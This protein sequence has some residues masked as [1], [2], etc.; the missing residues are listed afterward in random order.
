M[1]KKPHCYLFPGK[2]NGGETII[3]ALTPYWNTINQIP[4]QW[5]QHK[6]LNGINLNYPVN[7]KLWVDDYPGVCNLL[8][9]IIVTSGAV[10]VAD[11]FA[12][13]FI[14]YPDWIKR[15]GH[16][17]V[18]DTQLSLFLHHP[19]SPC[20]SWTQNHHHLP[21]ASVHIWLNVWIHVCECVCV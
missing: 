4:Q 16:L 5:P 20:Y 15:Q 11:V 1:N 6:D 17:E 21:D 8:W 3:N 9:K 19:T 7:L 18:K 14:F 13:K 2:R 12:N 10:V